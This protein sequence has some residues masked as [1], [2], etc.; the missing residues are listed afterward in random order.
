MVLE[1]DQMSVFK[2]NNQEALCKTESAN[3]YYLL[4]VSDDDHIF[5][6]FK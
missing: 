3:K 6:Y 1:E 4:H 2:L 5:F